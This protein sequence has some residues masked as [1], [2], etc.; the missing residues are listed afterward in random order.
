MDIV[1]FDYKRK[2]LLTK[3]I[4][5]V[6]FFSANN[7]NKP[8]VCIVSDNKIS[9]DRNDIHPLHIYINLNIFK[10]LDSVTTNDLF[11]PILIHPIHLSSSLEDKIS[12]FSS[13]N[14]RK[15]GVLFAGNVDAGYNKDITK[16]IFGYTRKEIFFHISN[17]LPGDILYFPKTIKEFEDKITTGELRHKIVLLDVQVFAI[18]AKKYF[19][20]LLESNFFIYMPGET[21]P[22]CHNQIESMLAGCIPITHLS[23]YFIPPFVHKHNSLL[24]DSLND[25]NFLLINVSKGKYKDLSPFLRRNILNY[26]SHHYANQSLRNKINI[27]ISNKVEYSSY[28][29]HSGNIEMLEELN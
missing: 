6:K 27:L 5:P 26:Y 11:Y 8:Y 24:F 4:F 3:D 23:K 28:Y 13:S 16:K 17:T 18:P 15:I 22:Y 10:N 14:D 29:I 12:K 1:D 2:T 20:I 9:I 25:L 19:E 7:K 21:Q